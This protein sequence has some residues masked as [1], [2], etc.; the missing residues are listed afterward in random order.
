MKV[1]NAN[2][3]KSCT[4]TILIAAVYLVCAA[5]VSAGIDSDKCVLVEAESFD[6]KG[7]WVVDQQFTDQMGSPYLLA[8]GL[9]ESVDDAVTTVT[10]PSLGTY[11][12]WVRTKNWAPGPWKSP[13]RFK[14]AVGGQVLAETFGT[15]TGW[16][17]HDGGSVT[18][19]KKRV[20]IRLTDLTGFDGRCDAIY[21]N[22]DKS[23][24]PPDFDADKRD[25]HRQWRNKLRGLPLTPPD[26]GKFD[27]VIVG[28]G[29]TGCAAALAADKQGL[30]VALIHDR[31]LLGGNA[32]N[33]KT[34]S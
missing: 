2:R 15:K 13:G 31:Q 4:I 8:H 19:T 27:V 20:E 10:F 22:T 12:V 9:G 5:G 14:V 11:K 1:W 21:F 23:A 3:K 6:N 16:N 25:V 32:A 29:I 7:G 18:I 34:V 24:N 33:S 28:G 17:W 26:G 30:S